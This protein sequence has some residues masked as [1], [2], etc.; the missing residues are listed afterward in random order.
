MFN[1]LIAVQPPAVIAA[2]GCP[3]PSCQ[4]D[5]RISARSAP[6]PPPFFSK[7]PVFIEKLSL[8]FYQQFYLRL[9]ECYLAVPRT[10]FPERFETP[11]DVSNLYKMMDEHPILPAVKIR[12]AAGKKKYEKKVKS[13]I[14]CQMFRSQLIPLQ[15]SPNPP[16]RTFP[17]WPKDSLMRYQRFIARVSRN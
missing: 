13:I 12:R 15:P 6:C 7:W 4:R 8:S 3:E 16:L 10:R 11:K 2:R 9:I 1:P 5:T 14:L 17:I